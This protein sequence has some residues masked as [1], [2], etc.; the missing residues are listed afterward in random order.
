MDLNSDDDDEEE[1]DVSAE[2]PELE[3]AAQAHLARQEAEEDASNS[4]EQA[5]EGDA[6]ATAATNAATAGASEA[7]VT[8]PT[9]RSE[10]PPP[11]R[12][13]RPP[14]DTT[15]KPTFVCPVEGCDK[16]YT[17][18]SGLF[19]HKRSKHPETI[20]RRVPLCAPTHPLQPTLNAHLFAAHAA[21]IDTRRRARDFGKF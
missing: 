4:V 17:T 20:K 16:A 2:E 7:T 10:Q 13:G 12:P 19:K 1:E 9:A 8:G 11:K 15:K 6:A 5:E 21:H 18:Y 3:P 14:A